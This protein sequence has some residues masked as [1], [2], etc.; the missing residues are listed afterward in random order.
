MWKSKKAPKTSQVCEDEELSSNEG[1]Q[2]VTAPKM[3]KIEHDGL[4]FGAV[5]IGSWTKSFRIEKGG[6]SKRLVSK[7]VEIHMRFT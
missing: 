7:D 3:T 1:Q 4:N 5:V 6:V 2:G